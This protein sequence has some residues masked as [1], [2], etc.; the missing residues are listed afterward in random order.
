MHQMASPLYKE[1]AILIL[2]Y[3]ALILSFKAMLMMDEHIK[4]VFSGTLWAFLG[5]SLLLW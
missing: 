4:R 5:H 1:N 2:S 3:L